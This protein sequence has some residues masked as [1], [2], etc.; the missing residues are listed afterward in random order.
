MTDAP[1][2]TADPTD[3]LPDTPDDGEVGEADTGDA[4]DADTPSPPPPKAGR[5]LRAAVGV[6]LLL[7]LWL[8]FGGPIPL[9]LQGYRF[10]VSFAEATQLATEADVRISGV[11]VGRVK[12]GVMV[13]VGRSKIGVIVPVGRSKI[14]E[15]GGPPSPGV[16]VDTLGPVVGVSFPESTGL[17]VATSEEP[18]AARIASSARCFAARTGTQA[19]P[20]HTWSGPSIRRRIVGFLRTG[21]A[22]CSLHRK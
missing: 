10:G 6:G 14:G 20:S 15:A 11:P 2:D 4:A 9:K 12:I 5:D 1:A 13:P 22:G 16:R 7:F 8:A 18:H 17:L 19:A 3:G 21:R